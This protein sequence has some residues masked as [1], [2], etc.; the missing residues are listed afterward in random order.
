MEVGPNEP[1]LR[2]ANVTME[3]QTPDVLEL[4]P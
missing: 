1:P 4:G 2:E 3:G